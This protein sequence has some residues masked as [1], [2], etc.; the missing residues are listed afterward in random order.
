MTRR[1]LILIAAWALVAA[2]C[3]RTVIV[4]PAAL[5]S[6]D[7]HKALQHELRR[8]QRQGSKGILSG[9]GAAS[10]NVGPRVGGASTG[11]AG[12]GVPAEARCATNSDPSQG[13]TADSLKIG[14]IIPLTGALRPLGHQVLSVMRISIEDALNGS[15]H[16]PGPYAKIDWGCPTRDGVFGRHVSLEVYSLQNNTPEEAL[17]GMRRLIDVEHVFLVRDCYLES[18]LMGPAVAYQHSK[19]LPG[20]WCYFSD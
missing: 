11:P 17:G 9:A 16:I 10:V 3:G 4:V 13:F 7:T 8:E 18:N 1:R 12:P 20:V 19:G 14:T 2:A 15:T 5:N 6:A